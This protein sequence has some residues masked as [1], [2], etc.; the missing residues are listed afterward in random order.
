MLSAAQRAVQAGQTVLLGLIQTHGRKET[1]PLLQNLNQLPLRDIP[2]GSQ[3]LKEF[4]L[5]AALAAHPEILLVDE[6]P[7]S[8][9]PG[10]RHRKRWQDIEELLAAGIEVWTALNVQHLESLNGTVGAITGIRINET[11]PDTVLENADEI[12]LIDVTVDALLARLKA[13]KVYVPQQAQHATENFFKKG[14]LIALREIAL[15][16]L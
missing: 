13:G 6:L 10:L 9:A 15:T 4:D 2:Y 11:V 8:N 14:N 12:I 7:H 5:D 16:H 1:Q 3:T